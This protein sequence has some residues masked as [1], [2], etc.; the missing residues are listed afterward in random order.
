LRFCT[1][2]W[3]IHSIR[4]VPDLNL[5]PTSRTSQEE[6]L[7]PA[8]RESGGKPLFLTCSRFT[9]KIIRS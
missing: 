2:L 3:A 5:V 1:T 9:F 7:A 8:V 4:N 6:G